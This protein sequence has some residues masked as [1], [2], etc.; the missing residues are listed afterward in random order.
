MDNNQLQTRWDDISIEREI[1][2]LPTELRDGYR[3]LKVY[4]RDVLG[5]SFERLVD[6]LKALGVYH[7]KTTW[8]KILRGRWNR[9]ANG[10]PIKTPVISQEKLALAIEALKT[11]TRAETLRGEVPFVMT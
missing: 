10:D 8:S 4:T 11:N 5:R 9:G 6:Q 7:D 1:A 3:W 2:Y